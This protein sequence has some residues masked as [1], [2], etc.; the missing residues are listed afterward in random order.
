MERDLVYL[1]QT[2]SIY[3]GRIFREGVTEIIVPRLS[4]KP[5]ATEKYVKS[6]NFLFKLDANAKDFVT[7]IQESNAKDRNLCHLPLSSISYYPSPDGY[8]ITYGERFVCRSIPRMSLDMCPLEEHKLFY[9]NTSNPDVPFEEYLEKG[10][11]TW[12][13]GYDKNDVFCAILNHRFNITPLLFDFLKRECRLE[14]VHQLL[15]ELLFYYSGNSLPVFHYEGKVLVVP[16]SETDLPNR[17]ENL[18]YVNESENRNCRASDKEGKH[19]KRVINR[20]VKENTE[21]PW[22]K[23]LLPGNGEELAWMVNHIRS[24][25]Q[26]NPIKYPEKAK[27]LGCISDSLSQMDHC[28]EGGCLFQKLD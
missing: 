27:C 26:Q 2:A 1:I 17:F 6:L 21:C 13:G 28:G 18:Y 8:V 3:G 25:C 16:V 11:F 12:C 22:R 7:R 24:M 20:S 19:V 15:S 23:V 14:L 5:K 9:H 4:G 10:V